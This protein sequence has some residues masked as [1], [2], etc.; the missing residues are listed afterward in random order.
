VRMQTERVASK[1]GAKII[2]INPFDQDAKINGNNGQH[3]EVVMNGEEA[4]LH[5]SKL[6]GKDL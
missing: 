5:M 3:V 4:L 1:L 6:L 2:R